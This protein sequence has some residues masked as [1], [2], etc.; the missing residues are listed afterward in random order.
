MTL[1]LKIPDEELGRFLAAY[2]RG[3]F[4]VSMKLGACFLAY[5][6]LYGYKHIASEK[7]DDKALELI[8]ENFL[9]RMG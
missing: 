7:N 3:I 4:P 6:G 9:G 8:K 5:Y 1:F 2:Y